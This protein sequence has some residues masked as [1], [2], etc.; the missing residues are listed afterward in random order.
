MPYCVASER[1]RGLPVASQIQKSLVQTDHFAVRI[2]QLGNYYKPDLGSHHLFV[3]CKWLS[4]T[5]QQGK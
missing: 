4:T 5:Q 1:E 3:D 2:V